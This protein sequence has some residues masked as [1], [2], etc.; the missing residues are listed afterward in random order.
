M[1]EL[2]LVIDFGT[3]NVRVQAVCVATGG[4]CAS[5]VR[6]YN[7]ESP[8]TGYCELDM[9]YMWHCSE[10]CMEQIMEDI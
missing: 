5:S 9:E 2:I 1:K 7:I 4:I 8:Q 6:R 10:D 3:S